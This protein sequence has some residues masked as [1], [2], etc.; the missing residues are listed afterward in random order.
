MKYLIISPDNVNLHNSG[1][2]LMV[3]IQRQDH[4]ATEWDQHIH[5]I[6]TRDKGKTQAA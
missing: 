4:A 3:L 6:I 5:N 2:G 1:T